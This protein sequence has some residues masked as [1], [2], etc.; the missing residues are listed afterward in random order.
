MH[1]IC[2]GTPFSTA[3]YT[4]ATAHEIVQEVKRLEEDNTDDHCIYHMF[5][6]NEETNVSYLSSPIIE[7]ELGTHAMIILSNKNQA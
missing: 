7:N 6:S 2:G 1:H 5:V 4:Y 3:K